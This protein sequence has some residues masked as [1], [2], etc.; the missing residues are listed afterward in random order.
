MPKK[1]D[2]KPGDDKPGND[3]KPWTPDQ[4]L[5]DPDDEEQTQRRARANARL[6]HLQ[7][8]YSKP[9][10]KDGKKKKKLWGE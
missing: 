1:D 9:P 7:E 8:S 4:P 6:A 5:E 3:P 10:E 2:D